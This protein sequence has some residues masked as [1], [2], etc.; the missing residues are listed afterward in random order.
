MIGTPQNFNLKDGNR[1]TKKVT[2]A[3]SN[4]IRRVINSIKP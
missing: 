3:T 2:T 4:L 1:Q